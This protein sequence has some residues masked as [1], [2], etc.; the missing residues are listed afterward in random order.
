MRPAFS[1]DHFLPA[2]PDALL[3]GKGDPMI[4][5]QISNSSDRTG[6]HR[7]ALVATLAIYTVTLGSMATVGVIV[8]QMAQLSHELGASM[9]ELGFAIG[10][11]SLP[12]A[13]ISIPLGAVIDRIGARQALTLAALVALAADG[14]IYASVTLLSL[15]VALAV[16]GIANAI[17]ITA[18]PALLMTS[19][20]GAQQVRAMSLWSTYGP[21]G[22]ALGL[23][24]GA[25]FA[26]GPGWRLGIVCLMALM[27]LATLVTIA[28]LPNPGR[29]AA[30]GPSASPR[31]ILA[32]LRDGRLMRLSLAYGLIAGLSYGSSLAAPGFLARIHGVSMAASATA[33]AVAKIAAM[34]LG[35]VG[36]GW[37]LSGQRD[38]RAMFLGVCLFGLAAQGLLYFPGSGMALA[39]LA[40]I[41]WLFAYG[42]ISATSFVVLAQVNRDPA[43][44]GLASGLIGQI[45]SLA[46]FAAPSIYFAVDLWLSFVLI[47]AVALALAAVLFPHRPG[48]P[49][50]A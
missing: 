31:D 8:P 50:I 2:A 30:A 20:A 44:A 25:P 36:M 14:L 45:G 32:L 38:R 17:I 11:Y 16:A 43:R 37:L 12:A 9:G 24:I 21:A 26:D 46:C 3:R 47:A 42:A 19:L 35:G 22:Y 7:A 28:V 5:G 6:W 48:R 29:A 33:I 40:M 1:A 10:L 15:Q 49:P 23:L 4:S 41:V 18:A 39:T 27:G 34:L 13:L